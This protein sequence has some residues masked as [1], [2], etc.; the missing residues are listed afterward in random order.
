MKRIWM[1]ALFVVCG[2]VFANPIN[3]NA[4]PQ[5][6]Q[7]VEEDRPLQYRTNT[8]DESILKRR[9]LSLDENSLKA[10]LLGNTRL[11]DAQDLA[12]KGRVKKSPIEISLPL[13]DGSFISVSAKATSVLSDDVAARHPEIKTWHVVGVDNPAISGRIDFTSKG[14]HG[15]LVLEDGDTIFIDPDEDESNSLYYSLSKQ[16]NASHFKTEFNCGTHDDHSSSLNYSQ[17][18]TLKKGFSQSP[19][20]SLVTYRLAIAG[21]AEYTAS[22]G[23]TKASAFASIVTTI[24]RVNQVYQQDL[25]IN[26]Q[27]VSG[28]D[29]VYTNAKEDPYSSESAGLLLQENINNL[30]TNFGAENF[31]IGH[32]FTQ[33]SQGGLSLIGVACSD[34]VDSQTGLTIATKA[35]G[36]TGIPSPQGAVFSLY[37]IAHEIGHQLGATHTFNSAQQSCGSGRMQVT[38]VEPG[39][40]SSIMAYSGFCGSDNLQSNSDSMFHWASI[41]QINQHTRSKSCGNVSSVS[42]LPIANAGEDIII[43]VS[44]PF[45]LKG[46][47][48]SGSYTWDQMDTGSASSV[49]VDVGNNAIVRTLLPS[50]NPDRY[51]PRLSDLFTNRNSSGEIL[52]NTERS[53]NFAFVVRGGGVS[54]DSKTVTVVDTGSLFKVLSQASSETLFIGKPVDIT[55]QVADTDTAPINCSAVDIKLLR[56]DGSENILLENTANDGSET[57]TIP[58]SIPEMTNAR[59]MVACSTQSFFQVSTGAI[60]VKEKPKDVTPPLITLQG[61][62]L[63]QVVLGKEYVELGAKVHDNIDANLTVEI[64][65]E[66]DTQKIGQYKI[67]YS[68][69]DASG[70]SSKKNRVVKVI[71][72]PKVIV[73]T[74]ISPPIKKPIKIS[75][76]VDTEEPPKVTKAETVDT[77]NLATNKIEKTTSE[78]IPQKDVTEQATIKQLSGSGSIGFILLPLLGL[79][80]L[81]RRYLKHPN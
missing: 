42:G 6:W 79:I 80:G 52:P 37:Y 74:P 43:P 54:S 19:V 29:I 49:N 71:T 55:W 75:A 14:F 81:R 30:S 61:A 18:K 41:S 65:G 40:G 67:V 50:G 8:I 69:T 77:K 21:T 60:T 32:L 57:L 20:D 1:F 27:L 70:N 16:Q 45:L 2:T 62:S 7:D 44:T 3:P 53:L 33:G 64:S 51:I 10:L 38:A 59:M 4:S 39:S 23:G 63:T 17:K 24:N 35:G 46:S 12:Y 13:P 48:S 58:A 56:V 11:D 72:K 31:D 25:G 73:T 26:L 34:R 66:V 47:V 5:V 28:E 78:E 68:A 36:I 15:L 76:T 9:K 22:Q